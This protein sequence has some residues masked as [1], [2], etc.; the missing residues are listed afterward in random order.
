V[1][2]QGGPGLDKNGDYFNALGQL[3]FGFVEIGSVTPVAQAGND[4][5]RI[6]RLKEHQAIIN[7]LGFNNKGLEYLVERVKQKQFNGLLGI[8]V[9]K[10]R[11]T[12]LEKAH[13]DYLLGMR[14]AYPV[15]DYITVNISS[16]N[17]PGLR[18]LQLGE[19][20]K[21]L[22]K[23]LTE[24]RT[25]LEQ[26]HSR[27]VPLAIKVAPDMADADLQAFCD[28]T[29]QFRIDAIIAGN[30]T[31]ERAAVASSP[32]HGEAGGLSGKPLASR[33]RAVIACLA[34]RLQGEIPI[35]GV[36]GICSGEDAVAHLSAG[37]SLVQVYTG[38]IY[39]GPQLINEIRRDVHQFETAGRT[40][41]P[42]PQ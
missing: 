14:A 38:L 3:G 25:A 8:N 22:I 19:P 40:K 29:R 11:S 15:A 24:A 34:Q 2:T 23:I 36:G 31:A 41:A 4:K 13:E 6:F 20:L 5:P 27:F 18:D 21:Q 32:H 28:T 30:T 33:S 10:N 9:G 12:P 39:R 42:A 37:A 7:R 1:L 17:T 26:Q 35:I 16:P